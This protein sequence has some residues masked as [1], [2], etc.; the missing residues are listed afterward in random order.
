MHRVQCSFQ[1]QNSVRGAPEVPQRVEA[2]KVRVPN[3]S[4]VVLPIEESGGSQN[5]DA[6][7]AYFMDNFIDF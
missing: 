5:C 2:A 1:R 4:Q 3:L 7:V 6:L